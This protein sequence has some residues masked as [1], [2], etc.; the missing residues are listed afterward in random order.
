MLIMRTTKSLE[1]SR[2]KVKWKE[3]SM[4]SGEEVTSELVRAGQRVRERRGRRW[5]RCRMLDSGGLRADMP[6]HSP[7]GP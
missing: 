7:T 6:K 5:G 2:A 4:A 3:Q 1:D